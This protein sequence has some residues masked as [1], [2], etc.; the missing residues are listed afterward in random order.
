MQQPNTPLSAK[1]RTTL[2]RWFFFLLV[3]AF[4]FFFGYLMGI[5]QGS[6]STLSL[7]DILSRSASSGSL[8]L[9]R[10]DEV[11]KV[12]KKD[13]INQPISESDAV[14]G[15][16]RGMVESLHDPY[17]VF[18]N[19]NESKSFEDEIQGTFEGIGAEIGIK[20]KQLVIVAPLPDSPAERAGLLAGDQIITI[21]EVATNSL[22]LDE[23]V[24]KI[25]GKEGS[26]VTLGV[27]KRDA[28]EVKDIAV[29]RATIQVQSVRLS[30]IGT[31]AH[32]KVTYF[33]PQTKQEFDAAVNQL[34]LNGAKGVML[35]LRNDPGG[36][37]D[38]AV[39]VAS[40]FLPEESVVVIERFS[41]GS[42][43][44]YKAKNGARLAGLPTVIL[45]DQGSASASEI[46]AGALQDYAI[47]PVVGVQ[48][49]GKGSVQQLE[50]FEDG[51]SLKVTVA[52]WLTP[53]GRTINDAGIK[54]DEEVTQTEEDYNN[55]H[56]PQL[57]SAKALLEKK[58]GGS[59]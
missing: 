50:K 19:P 52:K 3:L 28:T 10:I 21:D 45:V 57:D 54:P 53:K 39:D 23:A 6:G 51:S 46:V 15:A 37:L 5:D 36:Y 59:S 4:G 20:K 22:S 25:R 41:D 49:F 9:D 13:Y 31:I 12:L 58:I 30:M 48:T 1:K 7:K 11:W 16:I 8:T 29:K 34:L 2:L 32:L 14:Y 56:D 27:R 47:G 18:F 26:T 35:D 17:T 42:E 55:D 44:T 24:Q 43:T 40:Q 33:G 38:A